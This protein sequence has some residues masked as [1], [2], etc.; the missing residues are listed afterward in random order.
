MG[1]FY[2]SMTARAPYTPTR[3][4]GLPWRTRP[5]PVL[6]PPPHPHPT[7]HCPPHIPTTPPP[8]YTAD[9]LPPPHLPTCYLPACLYHLPLAYRLLPTPPHSRCCR[10]AGIPAFTIACFL[11]PPTLSH[12]PPAP[13]AALPTCDHAVRYTH[14]TTRLPPPPPAYPACHLP[15]L[16]LTLTS[17]ACAYT[18]LYIPRGCRQHAHFTVRR[19]LNGTGAY[20]C[21]ACSVCGCCDSCLI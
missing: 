10:A 12:A 13:P 5:V 8:A 15:H 21:V 3:T 20:A 9:Y 19:R 7:P 2:I 16:H 4:A 11:Q 6:P 1:L 18:A 17:F 14:L